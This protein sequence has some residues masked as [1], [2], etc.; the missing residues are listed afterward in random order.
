MPNTF[1][2]LKERGFVA[3]VTDEEAVR[4]LFDRETVT[5]YIGFD[6]TGASLHVG[7]LF[8]VMFLAHLQ[9]LGHRPIALMGGGTA[10]IGDPSG[11]TELRQMLSAQ[12]I[13]N[14]VAQ[15]KTQ[16][17]RYLNFDAGGALLVNN[18]E[19]LL[20]L[21]YIAF[22]R[23]IGP[24]FSVNRMLAAE[25]YKARLETGLTF[26]EFN[27]QILQAYD[28]L[29]LH[30]RYGCA[31]QVGGDDQWGNILAGVD[32][33]RRMDQ[34]SV[35]AITTPL[36][37]TPDGKKMGKTAAG[38]VW[39]DPDKL[40]PYAYYQFWINT[41]DQN[42]GRFLALFTFLPLDE[43]RRLAALEGADLREA[44][45]TLAF[46]ATRITHGEEETRRA[47]QATEAVF[48]DGAAGADHL[49][50]TVIPR[51][52]LDSGVNVVELFVEAGVGQSKSEV[53]RLIQQGGA[54]VN[55]ERVPDIDRIITL[56]HLDADN[57]LLLRA[58][59]KR[60]LR[61]VA[62]G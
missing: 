62:E 61:I 53:R 45:K 7:H 26:L 35:E 10:M 13:E 29:M 12:A 30:R 34:G 57:A 32:L 11:K 16:M 48:G 15:I 31:I 23:D 50:T 1:D 19:W 2:V 9:R 33:I 20:G 38:A 42:V 3:Q 51:H 27:Y 28:F 44:K 4:N 58:G 18:A 39:L 55:G 56:E 36:I 47:R 8:Q 24:H 52:R 22:L 41:D 59:K 5:A 17:S 21:N 43:V 6:P 37:T 14:N 40:S 49:P 60:Y 25:T 54:S 46:E